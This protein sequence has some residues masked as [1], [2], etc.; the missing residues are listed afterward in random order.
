MAFVIFENFPFGIA[1]QATLAIEEREIGWSGLGSGSVRCF[2]EDTPGVPAGVMPS[3]IKR[4]A[5]L[6]GGGMEFDFAADVGADWL[7]LV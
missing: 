6:S 4:F 2:G 3:G 7:G 1:A 5:A